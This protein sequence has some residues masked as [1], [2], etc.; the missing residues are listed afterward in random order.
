MRDFDR[1]FSGSDEEVNEGLMV[2]KSG[3]LLTNSP[4]L[5]LVS[6]KAGNRIENVMEDENCFWVGSS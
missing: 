2:P 5:C 6:N 1:G 4:I 3:S